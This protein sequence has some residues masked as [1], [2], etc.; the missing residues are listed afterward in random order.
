LIGYLELHT[1]EPGLSSCGKSLEKRYLVEEIVEI[2][3]NAA[4][5]DTL[6]ERSGIP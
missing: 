5:P 1:L 4:W 6:V 2:G 3:G